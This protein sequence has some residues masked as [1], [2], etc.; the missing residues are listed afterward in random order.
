MPATEPIYAG[1]SF[2]YMGYTVGVAHVPFDEQAHHSLPE[3]LLAAGSAWGV[4]DDLWHWTV[5][6]GATPL[7]SDQELSQIAAVEGAREWVRR[8]PLVP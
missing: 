7:A 6:D 4:Q 1:L 3:R 8:H 2:E 5:C